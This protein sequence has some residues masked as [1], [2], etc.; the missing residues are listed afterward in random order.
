MVSMWFKMTIG[1][2]AAEETML[3]PVVELLLLRAD[4]L[5]AQ[6]TLASGA[7]KLALSSTGTQAM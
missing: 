4:D 3:H 2:A 5:S 1:L 6:G 7:R